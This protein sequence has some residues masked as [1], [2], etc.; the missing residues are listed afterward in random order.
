[1]EKPKPV[2]RPSKYKEEYCQMLLNHFQIPITEKKKVQVA[3]N[4]GMV[5]IEEE[6]ACELPMIVDFA[7]EIGVCV[8]TLNEWTRVHPEFSDAYK[9]A[10]KLQEQIIAKNAFK[11]RCNNTFAL[12]MLKCNHGWNDKAAETEANRTFTLKYPKKEDS[13]D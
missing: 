3:T 5:E 13:D 12:F 7:E 4:K 6:E 9:K 1:M 11:N 8:D 2:G 10:K